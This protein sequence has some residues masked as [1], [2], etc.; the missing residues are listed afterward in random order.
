MQNPDRR[1]ILHDI[2]I[3]ISFPGERFFAPTGVG[4][5]IYYI[6]VQNIIHYRAQPFQQT[7]SL[8]MSRNEIVKEFTGE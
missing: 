2:Q 4:G 8:G 5:L 6:G 7:W 3:N 1:G